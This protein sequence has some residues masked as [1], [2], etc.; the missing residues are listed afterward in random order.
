MHKFWNIPKK[1]VLFA[2]MVTAASRFAAF[3]PKYQI[4][5]ISKVL[6]FK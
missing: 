4:V 5:F 3:T 2:N 6:T 1:M